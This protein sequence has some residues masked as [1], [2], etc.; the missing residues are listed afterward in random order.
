MESYPH[1]SHVW[2]LESLISS[3]CFKSSQAFHQHPKK[4]S[5]GAHALLPAGPALPP[6]LPLHLLP[7]PSA[8]GSPGSLASVS[9]LPSLGFLLT[10]LLCQECHFTA[11][12]MAYPSPRSSF[13]PVPPLQRPSRSALSKG[14]PMT[15]SPHPSFSCFLI[16][17][18][19]DSPI[20]S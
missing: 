15:L 6:L 13:N 8:R 3:P 19:S 17:L 16:D 14:S 7:S 10:S 9:P 18:L 2:F 11:L 5:L 20:S 1:R 4:L 12:Q